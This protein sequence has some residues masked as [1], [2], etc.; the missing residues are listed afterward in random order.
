LSSFG[1]VPIKDIWAMLDSCAPG[2]TRRLR[3]HNYVVYFGK[4]SFPTLPV[5][6]HGKRENPG[7]QVGHVRQMV[8]QLNLD[9]ECVK[10]LLPQL[11]LK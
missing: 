10:R 6:K 3:E 9:L 8:R 2:H 5:G 7:I 4:E 1:Q 11:K